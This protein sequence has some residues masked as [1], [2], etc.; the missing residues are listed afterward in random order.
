MGQIESFLSGRAPTGHNRFIEEILRYSDTR[1]ERDHEYIQWLFPNQRPSRYNPSAPTLDTRALEEIKSSPA[2]MQNFSAG[3]D[4]LR[5]FYSRNSH[6]LRP[7]DHNHLRITRIIEAA[8][9]IMGADVAEEFHD[10][11]RSR[12]MQAGAIIPA[13][14]AIQWEKRLNRIKA[15]EGAASD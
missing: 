10:F 9:L 3:L 5:A 6:W 1:L 11:I 7:H 12:D 8:G 2:A 15:L 13:N 4:L 14:T